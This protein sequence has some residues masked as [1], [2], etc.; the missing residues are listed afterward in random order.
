M[1]VEDKEQIL[2]IGGK[3]IFDRVRPPVIQPR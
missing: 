3:G 1:S 2:E